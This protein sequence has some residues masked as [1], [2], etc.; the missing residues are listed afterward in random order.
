MPGRRSA[1]PRLAVVR[2]RTLLSEAEGR[3]GAARP[4][5]GP[6]AEALGLAVPAGRSA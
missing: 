4:V 5:A 1:A 2:G 6:G 3:A